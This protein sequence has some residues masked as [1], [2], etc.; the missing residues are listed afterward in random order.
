M[1]GRMAMPVPAVRRGKEVTAR[2]SGAVQGLPFAAQRMMREES[3]SGRLM[4]S[5]CVSPG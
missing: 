5:V 4:C 2:L 3:A 1:G